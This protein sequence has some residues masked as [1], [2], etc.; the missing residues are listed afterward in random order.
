MAYQGVDPDLGVVRRFLVT[1]VEF[2]YRPRPPYAFS[3]SQHG[4]SEQLLA[5]LIIFVCSGVTV[6]DAIKPKP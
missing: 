4:R 5:P 1:A 2:C 3:Y 6:W